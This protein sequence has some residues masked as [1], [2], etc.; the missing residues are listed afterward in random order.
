MVSTIHDVTRNILETIFLKG[1]Q[2]DIQ[3]KVTLF[4]HIEL[5]EVIKIV[6]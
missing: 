4:N 2:E 5:N 3:A 6:Q 1:F